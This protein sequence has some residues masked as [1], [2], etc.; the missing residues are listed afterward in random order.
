M[1]GGQAFLDFAERGDAPAVNG[2]RK[3]SIEERF[4][5]FHRA[6]PAVY[7]ELVRLARRAKAAGKK[8]VGMKQLFEIIRWNHE[9][10]TRGE[11]LKLN[12]SYSSRYARLIERQ[13]GDLKGLFETR[14]LKAA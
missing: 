3:L 13:E 5:A 4:R 11:D 2:E 8:R 12:N 1:I 6:N 9:V 14:T 7:G 10:E